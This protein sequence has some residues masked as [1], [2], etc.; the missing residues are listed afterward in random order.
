MCV[1]VLLCC[2]PAWFEFESIRTSVGFPLHVYVY[3][4]TPSTG[5]YLWAG[6]HMLMLHFVVNKRESSIW[7]FSA[8]HCLFCVSNSGH[9]SGDRRRQGRG[10]DE[11][12]AGEEGSSSS[13]E[14]PP[15]KSRSMTERGASHGNGDVMGVVG[16]Q[17]RQFPI[18][19]SKFPSFG[20]GRWIGQGDLLMKGD[21]CRASKLWGLMKIVI[22]VELNGCM[23]IITE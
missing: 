19:Q 5:Y 10:E 12:A 18:E 11:A 23:T 17:N 1:C 9:C 7:C 20:D 22:Y 13:E 15:K 14:P 16:T 4:P 6:Q 3:L 2:R 21:N 8:S